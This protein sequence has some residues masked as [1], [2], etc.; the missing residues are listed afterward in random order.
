MSDSD[1]FETGILV[2]MAMSDGSYD[3]DFNDWLKLGR[4][5]LDGGGP[6]MVNYA[7]R[8]R[9]YRICPR[10][11]GTVSFGCKLESTTLKL[12]KPQVD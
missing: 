3:G 10:R 4:C 2:E 1:N 8:W 5:K 12:I 11:H 9:R 7:H 6:L